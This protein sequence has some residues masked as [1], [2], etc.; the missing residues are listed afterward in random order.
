MLREL[1]QSACSAPKSRPRK[2][3][4]FEKV[5]PCELYL[6]HGSWWKHTEYRLKVPIPE[7]SSCSGNGVSF[8]HF[9]DKV[10][11]ISNQFSTSLTHSQPPPTHI[12]LFSSFSLLTKNEVS[13]FLCTSHPATCPLDLIQFHL[14]QEISTTLLPAFTHIINTSLTTGNFLTAFNHPKNTQFY[15]T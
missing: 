1:N 9:T 3:R 8:T 4:T 10:A 14:Q 15:R 12:Q 7:E 13:K 2:F 6:D 5:L 11:T